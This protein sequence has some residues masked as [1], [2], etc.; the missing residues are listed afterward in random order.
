LLYIWRAGT[1]EIPVIGGRARGRGRPVAPSLSERPDGRK[2][3]LSLTGTVADDSDGGRDTAVKSLI[4][5]S[6]GLAVKARK[7]ARKLGESVTQ[8]G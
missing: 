2:R 6:E 3:T 8:S 4:S 5:G 7:G 1:Y